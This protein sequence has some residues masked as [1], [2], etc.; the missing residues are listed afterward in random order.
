M[1]TATDRARS[2]VPG[3]APLGDFFLPNGETSHATSERRARTA[4]APEE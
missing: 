2:S 3:A 4:P 1:K